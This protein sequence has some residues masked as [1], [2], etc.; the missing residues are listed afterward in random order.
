MCPENLCRR[1]LRNKS[2]LPESHHEMTAR[3]VECSSYVQMSMDCSNI[4]L[5][6]GRSETDW[7]TR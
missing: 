2:V 3:A 6:G 5:I 4:I 1:Q 7:F